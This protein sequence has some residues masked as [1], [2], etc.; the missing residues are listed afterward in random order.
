MTDPEDGDEIDATRRRDESLPALARLAALA[1]AI[2][3]VLP[4]DPDSEE[5]VLRI[6]LRAWCE[7]WLSGL[8]ALLLLGAP[9]LH[10][11]LVTV[12]GTC[13]GEPGGWR[14]ERAGPLEGSAY[15]GSTARGTIS[16]GGGRSRAERRPSHC[17]CARFLG[18]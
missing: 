3:V 11:A 10:G 18:N 15:A 2:C 9:Y 5:S 17:V 16:E 13:R 12:A 1:L 8:F 7:D 6:I 4:F 14:P